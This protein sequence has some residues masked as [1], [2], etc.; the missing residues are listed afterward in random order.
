MTD[1]LSGVVPIVPTPFT[2]DEEIDFEGLQACVGFAER[3]GLGAVCLPAYASEFYKLSDS[4]RRAVVT[5]AIDAGG[6]VKIVAQANHPSA[7]V[8]ARVAADYEGLGASF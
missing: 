1:Q 6:R 3:S 2:A 7:R 8:A 4:E 5:E